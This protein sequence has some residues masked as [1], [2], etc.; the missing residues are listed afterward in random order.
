MVVTDTE[1]GGEDAVFAD[2]ASQSDTGAGMI[3]RRK[4][5]FS[6]PEMVARAE[7]RKAKRPAVS[8]HSRSPKESAPT[9]KAAKSSDPASQV[10]LSDVAM[11][12][13]QHMLDGGIATVIA[14]FEAKFERMQRKI[15]VLEGEVMDK[16]VE[17]RSLQEQL[18]RQGQA[19]EQLQEQT[20]GIDQNRRL[21]MLI[22]TCDD[23]ISRT[24][25]EDVEEKIVQ[26]LNKRFSWLNMTTADIQAAHRLQANNK[27]VVRFV[28]RR[29]R[30][31]VYDGRFELFNAKR[32]SNSMSDLYI[33]ESLT[34]KNR[35]IYSQLLEARKPANGS[36]IASVFSRRGAVFCRLVKGGP[37]VRVADMQQLRRVLGGERGGR[38]SRDSRSGAVPS[39]P[40]N[41]IGSRPQTTSAAASP[42]DVRDT[43][44]LG[45]RDPA[46][47]RS[48]P[49]SDG[50]RAAPE[51][52]RPDVSPVSGERPEAR[53][54][55]T[56]GVGT[57]AGPP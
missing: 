19:L 17:I 12:R 30:D 52:R 13:I 28:K 41:S 54:E 20:E 49:A 8:R 1:S 32:S 50:Q 11:A 33:T 53:T 55:V 46:A 36:K 14:A 22:L 4:R 48:S 57:G 25:D 31:A 5:Q 27:V 23:F 6:V 7:G 44:D 21:S 47:P 24:T 37:N 51:G 2:A 29:V 10:E 15:E 38:G 43:G 26:V 56:H 39:P 35:E 45:R 34:P 18:E 16:D 40:S 42:R 3:G 9:S